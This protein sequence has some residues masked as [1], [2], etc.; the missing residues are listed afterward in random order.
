MW[1]NEMPLPDI[2]KGYNVQ[3]V[4]VALHSGDDDVD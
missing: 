1:F 2:V 3:T 4:Y